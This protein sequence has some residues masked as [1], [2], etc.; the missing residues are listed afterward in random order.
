M[1]PG[2]YDLS[3][4]QYHADEL[5][6]TPTLSASL[7]NVLLTASPAHAKAAHPK[8]NP[9]Y[10]R[11]AEDRFDVGIAAHKLLLEGESA[12][13]V[14]LFDNW[15]LKAAQ[16][17]RDLARAHGRIP[18]LAHEA[19]KVEA[20]VAALRERLTVLPIRPALFTEGKPEQ[21]VVWDEGGIA[22]RA[23]LDWLHDTYAAVDDLKTTSRSASP[24]S[25]SKT[26]YTMG[27]HVQARL[28]QRAVQAVTGILPE[29]RFVVAETSAPYA[30]S[31]FSL[32]PAG[33]ALADTQI[34]YVL[35][36]WKRC[37]ETDSWPA[38]P[39]R[40]CYAEPPG[41]AESQWLEREYR[42]EMQAA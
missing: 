11:K 33:V 36:L 30:V 19:D 16:E 10:E 7:A 26:L 25:F 39:D 28:Y 42:E 40:I 14:C 12:V 29:F 8:L 38:Y 2:V 32:A 31:V 3:S 5:G 18:L 22:C 21:T 24:E 15:R 20:M 9:Q 1:T 34:D 6:D 41:W 23:R 13:E 35:S 4:D 17:Q 27:Y 37:L